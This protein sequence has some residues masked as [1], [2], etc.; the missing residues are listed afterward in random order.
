MHAHKD[1]AFAVYT[2]NK[3]NYLGLGA[4]SQDAARLVF[5]PPADEINA[6]LEKWLV[7]GE[8]PRY[9]SASRNGFKA[10]FPSGAVLRLR[11]SLSPGRYVLELKDTGLSSPESLSVNLNGK[12]YAEW[13]SRYYEVLSPEDALTPPILLPWYRYG[14]KPWPLQARPISA[15]GVVRSAMTHGVPFETG[16]SV[17]EISLLNKGAGVYLTGEISVRNLDTG[18]TKRIDLFWGDAAELDEAL[19]LMHRGSVLPLLWTDPDDGSCGRYLFRLEKSFR[20]VK[21][22]ACVMPR[23]GC[24]WPDSGAAALLQESTQ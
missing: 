11:F 2:A 12:G 16:T 9:Y 20:D 5:S 1:R 19:S 7:V 17:E 21:I 22:F 13:A 3:G 14:T 15:Y 24:R 6:N 10:Y 18:S 8:S 4:A 23:P